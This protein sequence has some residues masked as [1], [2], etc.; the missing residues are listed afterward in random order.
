M[1]N[2]PCGGRYFEYFLLQLCT[3][4]CPY[5]NF[6]H[7]KFG[8]YSPKESQLEQSCT[9][10]PKLIKVHAGSFRVS[11]I[12]Q[13]LT[14]TAGTLTCVRDHSH[15]YACVRIHTGVGHTD[16]SAQ[17]FWLGNTLTIFLCTPGA[18]GVR[19]T[20]RQ[21]CS[22]NYHEDTSLNH[23]TTVMFRELSRGHQP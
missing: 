22:A 17:H 23:R 6:S 4:C 12:H 11:I 15:S 3:L 5:R 19:T 10:Q 1:E 14:R 8:S 7:G 20:G 9:T 21:W 13:T 18:G 16:E 2:K